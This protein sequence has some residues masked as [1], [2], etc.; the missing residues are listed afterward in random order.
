MQ[1]R[2]T[3][4]SEGKIRTHLSDLHFEIF[5]N[6]KAVNHPKIIYW[7]H[8]KNVYPLRRLVLKS[9]HWSSILSKREELLWLQYF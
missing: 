4:F 1:R 6:L 8:N 5:T 9:E 2:T 3:F 7:Y